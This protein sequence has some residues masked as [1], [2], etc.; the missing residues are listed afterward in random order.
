MVSIQLPRTE[1][2]RRIDYGAA[3]RNDLRPAR[4]N[5]NGA[6]NFGQ[7]RAPVRV[8]NQVRETVGCWIAAG[9]YTAE[10]R[11]CRFKG[12]RLFRRVFWAKP[13]ADVITY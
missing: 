9:P 5:G 8:L 12:V 3:G 11:S 2:Y 13:L 4:G 7:R 10:I 6:A 1:R